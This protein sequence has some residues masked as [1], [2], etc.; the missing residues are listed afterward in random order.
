MKCSKC[1]T[2]CIKW[3]ICQ[4]CDKV[5]VERQIV[6]NYII[7]FDR[8]ANPE[9]HQPGITEYEKYY[10]NIFTPIFHFYK[11]IHDRD[12]SFELLRE[13][14]EKN[15]KDPEFMKRFIAWKMK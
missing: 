2:P 8:V 14:V 1:N 4:A 10:E 11:P 12:T 5:Q 15:L 13:Q 9:Y 7:L 6:G 3:R